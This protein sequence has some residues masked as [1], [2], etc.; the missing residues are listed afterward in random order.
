MSAT[1]A[2]RKNFHQ[3]LDAAMEVLDLFGS[4]GNPAEVLAMQGRELHLDAFVEAIKLHIPESKWPDEKVDDLGRDIAETFQHYGFS[5]CAMW[6]IA[7]AIE[8]LAFDTPKSQ[9]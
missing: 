7:H 8:H 3:C 4:G 1:Q 6:S 9:G 2:E 5:V